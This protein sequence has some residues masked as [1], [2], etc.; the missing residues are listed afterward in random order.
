MRLLF[1]IGMEEI[2]ARFLEQA[3][4]DLKKNCEK[5]LKEKRVKFENIKTYGTPRRLIL[6][7]ENF[8]EKQEELNELSVGPSKEI[9]YKDGV[10]SKAGQG[11]IKSQGAEEK[12]IEIVKSDKGEYIAIRKQ[13]SGEKTEALLPEILKELTL[14]LSFPKSMKWADKSLRFARPIEWFLAVTEDNNKEFKVINFD[15]EGIKS[16]NK[17]KGH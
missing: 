17:S 4:A 9:A 1:E 15:I 8:S 11:F 13:S 12:D 5:K 2:P 10:L 3:L 16:S 6:G 14:E 7:V